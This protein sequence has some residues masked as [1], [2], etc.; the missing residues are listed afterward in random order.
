M[1]HGVS[2]GL[3]VR[4]WILAVAEHEAAGV[5]GLDHFVDRLLAEVG[6]R[7][8]LTLTLGNEVTD[9]LDAGALEA[10]VRAHAELELLDEDVVHRVRGSG[11]AATSGLA[12]DEALV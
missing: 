6:D 7:V 3:K 11:R 10:V 5:Q 9:G 8:E 1:A 4:R 2:S 12:A